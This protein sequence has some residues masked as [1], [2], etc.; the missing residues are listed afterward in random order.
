MNSFREVA[1]KTMILVAGMLIALGGS[2]AIVN[3]FADG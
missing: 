2:A 1:M 3:N